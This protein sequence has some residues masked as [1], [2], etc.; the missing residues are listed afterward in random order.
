MRYYPAFLD[1]EGKRCVVVGGGVV[2]ARKA[3]ALLRAGGLVRVVAP[4][5]RPEIRRLRGIEWRRARYSARELDGA[6]LVIA[7]T[8]DR[9]VQRA[10]WQDAARR[11]ILCSLADCAARSNFLSPAAFRRGD[12]QVAVSTGGAAPALARRVRGELEK[13]FGPEYGELLALLR[14]LRPR[15]LAGVAAGRRRERFRRMVDSAALDLLRQG[16]RDEARR[17]LESFL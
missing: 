9:R 16:R 14:E 12:L 3:E 13:V 2:A 15:V 8:N 11:G 6:W 17:L 10:V 4:K 7:A 5:I 1:I